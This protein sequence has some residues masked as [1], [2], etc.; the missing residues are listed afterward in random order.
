MSC[1]KAGRAGNTE[2][3]REPQRPSGSFRAHQCAT[4]PQ[5][6]SEG[7]MDGCMH[8]GLLGAICAVPTTLFKAVIPPRSRFKVLQK[9][10]LHIVVFYFGTFVGLDKFILCCDIVHFW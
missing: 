9:S 4:E 2:G 3:L 10:H 1:R 6:A 5:R 8:F 7:K